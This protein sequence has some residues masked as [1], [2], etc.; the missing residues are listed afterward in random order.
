MGHLECEIETNSFDHISWISYH[1]TMASVFGWFNLLF[2]FIFSSR[3]VPS[4]SFQWQCHFFLPVILSFTSIH[5]WMFPMF[6][7]FCLYVCFLTTWLHFVFTMYSQFYVSIL[8]LIVFLFLE[9]YFLYN[10]HLLPL[11][12]FI[13]KF[14]SSFK[15]SF[16]FTCLTLFISE[17]PKSLQT[18]SLSVHPAYHLTNLL[19]CIFYHFTLLFKVYIS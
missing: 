5:L 13:I 10:C 11:F 14:D 1:V 3:S 6:G 12:I 17:V 9:I 4:I 18:S 16:M 8:L 15:I 2:F 7:V 19:K